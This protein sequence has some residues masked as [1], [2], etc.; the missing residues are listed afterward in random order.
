MITSERA[1]DVARQSLIDAQVNVLKGVDPHV[2]RNGRQGKKEAW[3][4]TFRLAVPDDF[5]P[6]EVY[7]HV[8]DSDES[9]IISI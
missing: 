4:V 1:V 3:L 6:N 7:V 2:C 9:T 8:L 5:Q